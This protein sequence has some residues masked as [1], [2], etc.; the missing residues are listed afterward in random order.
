MEFYNGGELLGTLDL[1]R[2]KPEIYISSTNRSGGKTTYFNRY[3]FKRWRENMEK[4]ML[5]YR[6]N[7]ELDNVD[8][9]FFKEINKLFYPNIMMRSQ[10]AG[11]G[12]Y[13]LLYEA[14]AL[15]YDEPKDIPWVHCGYAVSLNSADYIKKYSH[16]FADT[17]RMIFDEFQSE[18]G[19]YIKNEV[20]KLISI[21]TSVARGDG[22]ASRYVP[23]IMISNPV[24]I[25]N[26]YYVAMGIHRRI[27]GGTRFLRGH[28]WVMEQGYVESASKAQQESRFNVAFRER[29]YMAYNTQGVYLNDNQAFIQRM[30]GSSQYVCGIL[31]NGEKY[32]IR[33]FDSGIYYACCGMDEKHP[34]KISVSV[35][36]HNVNQILASTYAYITVGLRKVFDLGYF[37]FQNVEAKNCILDLLAYAI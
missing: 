6:Y 24:S 25:L 29:Q 3:A 34:L 35:N 14:P 21:H 17:G 36:D 27:D 4:F 8:D 32:S 18:T 5:I 11:H 9:K 20:D 15:E 1:D 28:G 7:N 33:R 23:I 10:K 13:C 19:R 30:T 22:K 37:R 2:V 12:K 16:L 26:P 31:Y